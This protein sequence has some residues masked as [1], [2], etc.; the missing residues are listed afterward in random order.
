MCSTTEPE[1]LTTWSVNDATELAHAASIYIFAVTE[2]TLDAAS[3]AFTLTNAVI[4]TVACGGIALESA[5][6]YVHVLRVDISEYA[7][8]AHDW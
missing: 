4:N 3:R 7:V 1:S 2:G 8:K 5:P 6:V